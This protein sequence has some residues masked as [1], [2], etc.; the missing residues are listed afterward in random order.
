MKLILL[1]GNGREIV[2][3]DQPNANVVIHRVGM[4]AILTFSP[5][6]HIVYEGC[7]YVFKGF[8]G[9]PIVRPLDGDGDAIYVKED[10]GE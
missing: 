8:R 3:L 2:S 6:R 1:D 7:R 4:P 10:V 9:A 5:D